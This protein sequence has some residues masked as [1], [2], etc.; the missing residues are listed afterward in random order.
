[1]IRIVKERKVRGLTQSG[2]PYAEIH[3]S[4]MCA[5]RDRAFEALAGQVAKLAGAELPQERADKLFEEVEE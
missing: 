5:N 4:S 2:L 3:V 1:L